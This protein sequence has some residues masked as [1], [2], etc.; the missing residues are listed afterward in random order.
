MVLKYKKHTL[1]VGPAKST[2][3]VPVKLWRKI[4]KTVSESLAGGL[5][6]DFTRRC[7]LCASRDRAS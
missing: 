4:Q 5:P 1:T 6:L 7:K 3:C 2:L